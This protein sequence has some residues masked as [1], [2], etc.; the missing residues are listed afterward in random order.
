MV[1]SEFLE[2]CEFFQIN[3]LVLHPDKT[4]FILFSRSNNSNENVELFCN[5]NNP[6]QNIPDFIH[7]ISRV[8]PTDD[9]PAIKFLGVFFDPD[10]N[11][12]FHISTLKIKLSK[13]LLRTQNSQKYIKY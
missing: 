6:N 4:K 13:A 5:N 9:M 1:N 11:L 3:K 8:L 2:V 7:P 10:L 12:K